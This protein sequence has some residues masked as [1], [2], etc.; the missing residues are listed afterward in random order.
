MADDFQESEVFFESNAAGI[1]IEDN[2][3]NNQ[4]FRFRDSKRKKKQSEKKNN[5]KSVPVDIP[6]NFSMKSWYQCYEEDGEI[7]PPHVVVGRRRVAG[8]MACSV[9]SGNGRTLKGR[10]LSQVRNSIL[11]MTGFL[12]T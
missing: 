1:R 6:E 5:K 12:E 11:K 2:Y 10:D 8:E 4:Q 7:V 3:T 9:C